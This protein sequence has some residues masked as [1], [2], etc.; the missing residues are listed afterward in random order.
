MLLCSCQEPPL[1][2]SMS[3]NMPTSVIS[4]LY[5]VDEEE[6]QTE[7]QRSHRVQRIFKPSGSPV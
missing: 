6:N 5:D 1:V 7:E 2:G 4:G 3:V